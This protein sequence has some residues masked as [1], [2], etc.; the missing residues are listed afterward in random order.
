MRRTGYILCM[1][2]I[3][4]LSILCGCSVKDDGGK[5][6]TSI[7]E[8]NDPYTVIADK[9]TKRT[10]ITYTNMTDYD[11]MTYIMYLEQTDS[12]IRI[13]DFSDESYIKYFMNGK[14]HFLYNSSDFYTV[15]MSDIMYEYYLLSYLDMADYSDD[16][17]YTLVSD[18]TKGQTRTVVYRFDLNDAIAEDFTV[19]SLSA[20]D[21]VTVTYSLGLDMLITGMTMAVDGTVILDR[22]EEYSIDFLI[23]DISERF[24]GSDETVKVEVWYGFGTDDASSTV[25]DIPEGS[26]FGYDFTDTGMDLYYD[27]GYSSVYTYL[28]GALDMDITLYMAPLQAGE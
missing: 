5:L 28:G 26:F 24:F 19:W 17:A 14:M 23:D 16:T 9:G 8:S 22:A 20:G 10:S 6:I 2:L 1:I 27:S 12:G 25:Y 7:N 11:D 15:I 3:L 4:S 13:A 18:N 21:T